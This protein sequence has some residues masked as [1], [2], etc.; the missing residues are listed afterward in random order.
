MFLPSNG[1][2]CNV[3]APCIK[4]LCKVECI[5]AAY[6]LYK[7]HCHCISLA[8]PKCIKIES[9]KSSSIRYSFHW[10]SSKI[11]SFALTD[12]NTLYFSKYCLRMERIGKSLLQCIIPI[13]KESEKS[14]QK[15]LPMHGE[16]WQINS[17]III[18]RLLRS[19]IDKILMNTWLVMWHLHVFSNAFFVSQ[20][21]WIFYHKF[22]IH[23]VFLHYEF[24][25]VFLNVMTY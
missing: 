3:S 5:F 25:Y 20:F 7:Q 24:A 2:Q 11:R 14:S 17:F 18:R 19:I 22:H 23:M 8:G 9:E 15:I 21:D 4:L 6:F 13:L 1:L 10:T 12:L 16:I